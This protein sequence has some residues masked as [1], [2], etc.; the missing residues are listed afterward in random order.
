MGFV[1]FNL[2]SSLA[3]VEIP[4]SCTALNSSDSI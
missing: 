2:L 4:L 3:S 1:L